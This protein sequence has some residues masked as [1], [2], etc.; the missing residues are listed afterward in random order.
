MSSSPTFVLGYATGF[1]F[2]KKAGTYINANIPK[3][4][5]S[6]DSTAVAQGIR[7]PAHL[8]Y[9]GLAQEYRSRC[10]AAQDFVKLV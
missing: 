7:V 10:G 6:R 9:E 3:T 5:V 1:E 2:E 8:Y 4:F